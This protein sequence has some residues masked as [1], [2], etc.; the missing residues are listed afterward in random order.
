[1]VK[2]QKLLRKILT[3]TKNVRFDEFTALIEAF[4]FRLVRITGSH[5]IFSRHN[6]PQTISVQ[7]GKNGQAKP[8][9][10]RQFVKLVEKYDLT[11]E[12]GSEDDGG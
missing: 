9:Q 4:G 1:M 2:K 5:H 10:M 3:G 12:N 7:E 6:V 8:Y 11:L